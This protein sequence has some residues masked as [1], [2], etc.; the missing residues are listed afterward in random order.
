M[1]TN[2][3]TST[4]RLLG[5][6]SVLTLFNNNKNNNNNNNNIYIEYQS[7]PRTWE[8]NSHHIQLILFTMQKQLLSVGMV[9]RADYLIASVPKKWKLKKRLR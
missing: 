1:S 4:P 9:T 5:E 7:S 8:K 6:G 3:T 2:S